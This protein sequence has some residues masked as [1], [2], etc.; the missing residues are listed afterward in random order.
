MDEPIERK[1][2]LL[3]GMCPEPGC[4]GHGCRVCDYTGFA[5]GREWSTGYGWRRLPFWP[6]HYI[7][8]IRRGYSNGWYSRLF[9]TWCVDDRRRDFYADG[10]PTD[11]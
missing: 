1:R 4:S 3:R 5:P 6:W 9:C 10:G 7:Q 8:H 2:D 11:G